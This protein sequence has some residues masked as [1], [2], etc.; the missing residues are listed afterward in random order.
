MSSST[1]S[2][3]DRIGAFKAFLSLWILL[4]MLSGLVFG[5]YLPNAF[6]MLASFNISSVNPVIAVLVWLLILPT[7]VEIDYSKFSNIRKKTTWRTGLKITTITNWVIKPLLLTGLGVLFFK[8]V[9]SA[10]IP[11]TMAD[12]YIAGLILLGV[13]P[14]TGMV[15]VW[16]RMTGGDAEFTVSQVSI[17]DI[18]LLFAYAP[19]AGLLL[20]ISGI[21]IPW[22]TLGLSVFAYVIIPLVSGYLIRRFLLHRYKCTGVIETFS[23]LASPVTKVGLV[24][25]VFLL[26]GLQA[27][28]ILTQP[29][30]VAMIATPLIIQ[31]YLIFAIAYGWAYVKRLP[32]SVAA[33]TALIGTS[34]FFELAVAIAITLF[35]VSS[36][37]A[38]ATTVG[39]L[40]EVP[41]MLSLVFFINRYKGVIDHRALSSK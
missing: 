36:P 3:T 7:M 35:G 22:S 16:S 41:I 5:S 33:P 37:A 34:N 31:G 24:L 29:L 32:N 25:V 1:E 39:V 19:I 8:L 18:I 17:N 40:T 27:E 10:W 14:C 9:F 6:Q 2:V 28:T 12:Q 4:A 21:S 11:E 23:K 38:I 13:A 30:I 20:G 26:F 15:F